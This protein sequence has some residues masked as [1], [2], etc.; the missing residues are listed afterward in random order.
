MRTF[1]E[2]KKKRDRKVGFPKFKHKGGHDSFRLTGSI[3]VGQ[4]SVK[5]PRLGKIRTKEQTDT[6]TLTGAR[7]TSATVKREA[8]RWFVSLAVEVERPDPVPV[9]GPRIGIDRG[10]TSFAVCSD[11]CVIQSPKALSK[12]LKKLRRLNKEVSRKKKGSKNRG[13]A[14]LR[15]ARHHRTIRNQRKDALHKATTLLAKTKQVIVVED[16]NVSGMIRNRRL[17]RAIADMGWGEFTRQLGYKCDWYGSKLVVADRFFPSTKT[18]SGCGEMADEV[19]LSKR[20]FACESCGLSI[21]R[22]LNA[23]INLENYVAVSLTETL[24]ACGEGSSG[25]GGNTLVKLPSLKQEPDR[26]SSSEVCIGSGER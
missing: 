13:L 9:I 24:N 8:D 25:Q 11:G 26:Q 22:D 12:G 10:I 14:R 23:A 16:L 20:I 6:L 3:H 19:L 7:I 15:L 2:S 17:S 4:K 1:F 5:L 21:D 18:C